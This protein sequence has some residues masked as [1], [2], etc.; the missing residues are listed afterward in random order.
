MTSIAR[1]EVSAGAEPLCDAVLVSGLVFWLGL[2]FVMGALSVLDATS[3]SRPQSA[4]ALRRP[5]QPES[6]HRGLG[7]SGRKPDPAPNRWFNI[8]QHLI[9]VEGGHIDVLNYLKVCRH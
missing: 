8:R 9:L 4:D 6:G 5:S 2:V 7:K 1:A 3:R